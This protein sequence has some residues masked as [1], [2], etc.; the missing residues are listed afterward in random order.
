[1]NVCLCNCRLLKRGAHLLFI[2]IS[3]CIICRYVDTQQI[4]TK[5]FLELMNEFWVTMICGVQMILFWGAWQIFF[6]FKFHNKWSFCTFI[7]SSVRRCQASSTQQSTEIALA[8]S[9]M[10]QFPNLVY[11]FSPILFFQSCLLHWT[12]I[13]S[14]LLKLLTLFFLV[15]S[16]TSPDVNHHIPTGSSSFD[17]ILTFCWCPQVMSWAPTLLY[18]QRGISTTPFVSVLGP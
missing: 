1:M 12:L 2:C 9:T 7:P 4:F 17:C 15:C 18:T 14:P 5:C 13:T 16:P 8:R 6:F 10:T 3:W 11:L